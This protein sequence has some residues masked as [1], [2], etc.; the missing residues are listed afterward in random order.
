MKLRVAHI[1][2]QLELGGAQ[3][4]T[5]YTV[6]QLNPERF[7]PTLICGR[8]G[9]LDAEAKKGNWPTHFVRWLVRPLRPWDVL[10]LYKIYKLL[11]QHKPHIVHTHSSKAG[12]LGRIAAY[13]A[14]IPVIIHTFHGF[15]FNQR[16]KSWTRWLFENLE[17]FCAHLSNHLIFVSEENRRESIEL[18]IGTKVPNSLIRSGIQMKSDPTP[19]KDLN[20]R[21]KSKG[22][23]NDLGIPSDAW[24]VVSVGNFK[25]QKNPMDLARVATIVLRRKPDIYFLLVGDGELRQTVESWVRE[26]QIQN[27][28]H[29]LGWQK[30]RDDVMKIL[31][32]S[33]CFLLTSLWEG[34]P[35]ALVE[36]FVA[37][38]P[39]IAYSVGGVKDI[40]RD[41][42]NGHLIPP[43][44]FDMAA[45]K[46]LWLANHPLEAVRMGGKG[47]ATVSQEFDIDTMV[48][49][50]ENLYQ[51]LYEAVPLKNYYE[52]LWASPPK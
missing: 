14:G 45:E 51:S 28:V 33:N 13:L 36:A 24:I 40:L 44:N 34:L 27:R 31:A 15:G 19:K 39:A 8:D 52:P 35:R 3:R 11:R 41:G 7:E 5:L 38:L 26:H 49:D 10:A 42:E 47:Q 50:Q 6:G 25:P 2:T 23:R 4:N 48:R 16:Q 1:I 30:R 32:E 46:I 17:R 18:R 20:H 43:G 29:F 21:R 37:R 22:V 12:I 9:I